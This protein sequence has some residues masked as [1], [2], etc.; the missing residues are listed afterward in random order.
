M[1]SVDSR[2]QTEV[3]ENK[4]TRCRNAAISSGTWISSG[5]ILINEKDSLTITESAM[6]NNPNEGSV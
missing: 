6:P 5:N 2:S 3:G 4:C 1:A